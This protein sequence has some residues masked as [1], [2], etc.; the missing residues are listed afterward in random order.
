MINDTNSIVSFAANVINSLAW[1]NG[2]F[3]FI[4]ILVFLVLCFAM[5]WG[6]VKAG[7]AVMIGAT[8]A[9]MLSFATSEFG[10]VFWLAVIVSVFVLINGLRKQM[11]G[12]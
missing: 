8:V 2:S 9:V 1:G 3:V 4:G 10:F 11:V 12:Y 5:I 7:T 6:R